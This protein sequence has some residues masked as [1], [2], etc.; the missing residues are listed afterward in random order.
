MKR[1]MF[2]ITISLILTTLCLDVAYAQDRSERLKPK[3]VTHS[4]PE[5][6][7]DTYFFVSAYAVGSSIDAA[8][9]A[10]FFNLS[11][12]LEDEHGMLINSHLKQITKNTTTTNS[13]KGSRV[14]EMVVTA[15]ER[16]R[17]INI[18]CRVID[19]W[20]E[21][22]NGRYEMYVLYAVSRGSIGGTYTDDIVVTAKYPAA[23]FLSIIPSVGQFYKGST[24]KGSII[25]AGEVAAVAGIILCENTRASYVKK[26][27]EQPKYAQQ[28]NSL[29]DN[30]ETGRN[31]CIG[32]AAAIYV[33]NLID[34]FVAKGAKHV[35]INKHKAN[36]DVVPY[37]DGYS[38]GIAMSLTF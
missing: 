8:R 38:A 27:Y 22:D 19:E 1:L 25:L 30:W 34:G 32:A 15:E 26:M 21:Y 23:G 4:L 11:K 2:I 12:R 24:V 28:Y 13:V 10:A 29:A 37:T 35:V 6:E 7:T 14:S 17:E 16:G 5:P 18:G 20:W 9:Q 31:I 3:W 33:Y 36:Y